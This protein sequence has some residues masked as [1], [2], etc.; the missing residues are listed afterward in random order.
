MATGRVIYK[1]VGPDGSVEPTAVTEQVA[2]TQEATASYAQTSIDFD[3]NSRPVVAYTRFDGSFRSIQVARWTGSAWVPTQVAAGIISNKLS[4]ALYNRSATSWRLAYVNYTAPSLRIASAGGTDFKAADLLSPPDD[5]GVDL[6]YSANS[7]SLVFRDPQEGNLKFGNLVDDSA[8]A[9]AL[10]AVEVVD[11]S[12]DVGSGVF[13]TADS[14]GWPHFVYLDR[15]SGAVKMARRLPDFTWRDETVIRK[16]FGTLANPT[17]AFDNDGHPMIACTDMAGDRL[18]IAARVGVTWYEDSIDLPD[19]FS[20]P[21]FL[22][23]QD[24]GGLRLFA[25]GDYSNIAASNLRSFGPVDDFVDADRDAVPLRFERAFM[26]NPA[27]PDRSKLP[28]ASIETV[29]GQR[30]LVLTVRQQPGGT[31]SGGHR[32]ETGDHLLT[33]EG[34]A[35]LQTWTSSS[36]EIGLADAFTVGGVR[37][38]SSYA[39][40]PAGSNGAIRFLRVR[41]DRK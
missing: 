17:L 19:F 2:L 22:S 30:R 18:R 10:G 26:M 5:A 34:S 31:A 6:E 24:S 1:L 8:N 25:V 35:D 33:V 4:L 29:G 28:F 40:D 3:E 32:Y 36:A 21:L 13:Y 15:D 16:T 37:F 27:L 20:K 7:G 38:S 39:I 9:T 41:V 23:P 12:A 14:S 11:G